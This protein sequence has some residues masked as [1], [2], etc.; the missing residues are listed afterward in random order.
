MTPLGRLIPILATVV[1][2]AGTSAPVHDPPDGGSD[3]D[4]GP[5]ASL[6]A[7]P[8]D[9]GSGL[10]AQTYQPAYLV[11]NGT[12]TAGSS[13]PTLVDAWGLSIG[14]TGSLWVAS[15][16]G[17]VTRA[18]SAAGATTSPAITIQ[19]SAAKPT[20]ASLPNG[21]VFNADPSFNGDAVIIAT[22]TGTLQGWQ[23]GAAAATIRVDNSTTLAVYKGLALTSTPAGDRLYATN[24]RSGTVEVYD[25]NYTP[26]GGFT[27]PT[28]P[29]GFAPFNVVVINGDLYVTFARQDSQAR[30]NVSGAGNGYVDIFSVTGQL[31]TRL[32]A[33]GVLNSP[34]GVARTPADFGRYSDV[35]LVA[36]AGDGRINVFDPTYGDLLGELDGPGYVPIEID[37]VHDLLFGNDLGGAPHHVLFFTA[38]GD[39]G[40][41]G[42]LGSLTPAP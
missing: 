42:T 34:Y 41:G 5:Q 37:G 3:D 38:G 35:V 40:A 15:K 28:I 2:C 36:N 21:V 23:P 13:D 33:R 30:D 11:S 8:A 14:D 12:P 9:A 25:G 24:F 6:D 18:Y 29:A 1:A 4:G 20:D 19:P 39:S 17:D 31:Q 27:D 16:D 32:I 22:D 10:I 26:L 7:G